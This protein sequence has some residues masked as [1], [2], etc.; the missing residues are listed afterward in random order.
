MADPEIALRALTPV[1]LDL[2][3]AALKILKE[4]LSAMKRDEG[5]TYRIHALRRSLADVE[6]YLAEIPHHAKSLPRRQAALHV[7][8]QLRRLLSREAQVA[9]LETLAKDSRLQ[10]QSRVLLSL[11]ERAEADP[12]ILS[13]GDLAEFCSRV[14][15]GKAR[16]RD[17]VTGSVAPSSMEV[18]EALN[19]MDAYRWLARVAHHCWRVSHYLGELSKAAAKDIIAPP[20][21]P[22]EAD[23][24]D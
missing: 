19:R 12:S 8:D 20:R 15:A 2:Y 16:Y 13:V 1:F 18:S 6:R 24:T 22:I 14:E 23:E 17:E 4:E 10:D 7:V 21:E 5:W 3:A 11:L 9:R